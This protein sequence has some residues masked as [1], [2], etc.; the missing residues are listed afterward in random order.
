MIHEQARLYAAQ[1]SHKGFTASNEWLDRWQKRHN[2]RMA[3]LSGE[4]A[5]VNEEM[6]EDLSKRLESLCRSYQLRDIFNADEIGLFYRSLPT[7]SMCIKGYGAKGG[8]K[9][10]DRI[11]VLFACS[12]EGEK[13]TPFVIGRN[14]N[15]RCFKGLA[16]S[17]CIP[18]SYSSNRKAWMT[19][20]LFQQWLD[21]LN[22]KM[23]HDNSSILLFIDNCTAHP[24]VQFSNVR[25]VFLP[26]NTISKLQP[27]DTGIIQ[28]TKMHYR[29]ILLCHVLL[30]MDEAACAS[31][32]AKSVNILYV[33]MWLKSA[34]DSVKLTTIQ[35]CFARC[36][37]NK[38]T[39]SDQEEEN[40]IDSNI[41]AL[42]ETCGVS[43]EEYANFDHDLSTNRTIDEDWEKAILEKAKAQSSSEDVLEKHAEE[44]DE[45][46][47][48][49]S[50]MMVDNAN[51]SP[52]M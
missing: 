32:L 29:K 5:D 31:D 42:V 1:F 23:K 50:E 22:S 44:K 20:E 11:S 43:W 30:R 46:E 28:A 7:K 19:A 26:P 18:V 51:Y 24:D 52:G 37:F 13:L 21:K 45:E 8:E 9:S 34:W 38:A 3:T 12:A 10:K 4:A 49:E 47:D 40:V 48:E 2:D 36:G 14:A 41:T 6:V 15:S 16:S 27:C 39:C 25:L 17:A 33:I 35:K